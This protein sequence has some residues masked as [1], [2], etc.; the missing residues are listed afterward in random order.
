MQN[1]FCKWNWNENQDDL[2]HFNQITETRK[3]SNGIQRST[4]E[5]SS[6]IHS[7][8]EYCLILNKE[9]PVLRLL[10]EKHPQ[11]VEPIQSNLLNPSI[12]FHLS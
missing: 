10:N 6:G 9:E 5:L 1:E 7:P 4:G 2:K 11:S 12:Q 3:I 8:K